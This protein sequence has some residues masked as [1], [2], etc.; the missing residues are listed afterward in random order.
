MV[1]NYLLYTP[2]TNSHIVLV[3]HGVVD[4]HHPELG[5]L[6]EYGPEGI[7]DVL[8]HPLGGVVGVIGK[9]LAQCCLGRSDAL[10][11]GHLGE[12]HGIPYAVPV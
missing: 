3:E 1:Q 10:R 7:E 11:T 2:Y 6:P 4:Q 12:V 5:V 9:L 8:R